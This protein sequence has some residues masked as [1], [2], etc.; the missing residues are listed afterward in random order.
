MSRGLLLAAL[1]GSILLSASAQLLLKLGMSAPAVQRALQDPASGPVQ[2]A[3]AIL[4]SPLILAGLAAFG[5][6]AGTWLLVLAR[7]ELSTA[8]PFVAL[9]IVLTAVAG[10]FLLGESMGPGKLAGVSLI[11]L[12]VLVLGLTA[13]TD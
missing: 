8:Y 9:G 10:V 6:S 11:V 3:A 4:F 1:V 2:T 12:G 7:V 5:A 13:A